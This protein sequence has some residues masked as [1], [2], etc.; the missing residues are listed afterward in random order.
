MQDLVI[1]IFGISTGIVVFGFLFG[2]GFRLGR[3]LIKRK[4]GQHGRK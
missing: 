1:H 2:F 4:G 3:N